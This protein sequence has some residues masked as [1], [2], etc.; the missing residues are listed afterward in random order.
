[1]NNVSFFK[2]ISLSLQIAESLRNDSI[3]QEELRDK[4][5]SI[6]CFTNNRECGLTYIVSY[7]NIN[8]FTFCTYE[9]RSSDQIII[10]GL[11][12]Y[13]VNVGDLPYN[14]DGKYYAKF[15][16]NEVGQAAETLKELIIKRIIQG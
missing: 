14:S 11:E 10:N 13:H 8:Y 7:D 2:G 12:G 16:Y 3:F 15:N 4:E 9:H 1:M 5:V 6:G